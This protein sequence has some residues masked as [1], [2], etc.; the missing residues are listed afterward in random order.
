MTAPAAPNDA[1]APAVS[2]LELF[3]HAQPLD[4][5][6]MLVGSLAALGLGA[7]QPIQ[8]IF[9]ADV[10]DAVGSAGLTG[11]TS[12]VSSD[13]ESAIFAFL[14]IAV[15]AF[16]CGFIGTFAWKWTGERQAAR[17]RM[18]YLRAIMRQD[19]AWHDAR[20]TAGL[21]S[22]FAETAQLVELGIGTKLSEGLRFLGQALGGVATGFYFEWDIALVLLA[23]APFSIGSAAGLNTVTRRTSQRMAEA[24]G[25]AGAVCAEVLG[26]V[27]T[28]ASFS[29]EPRE[30][31]R[32]EALLAPAEAVGIRSG[33]QRGLA[34]GAMMG[35]ENVLMAVGLVYGA[36]K[37]ASERARGE[38]NCAYTNSCKVSGGEVLLT[39]FAI[40]MGAQAFGFLGQA[41][42]ALSKA[43]TAAGRMKLTIERTPSIDAMSDEGLTPDATSVR[44]R[45][46]FAHCAFRYPARPDVP[47]YSDFSLV[48]E[49]GTTVALV[50]GSGSG[51]ST[52]VALVERFYDPDAGAVLLDG[53]DVRRLQLRWLRQR[54]GLVGQ[55]PTLFDG[56]IAQNIA[57]GKPDATPE[58]IEEAARSSNA[59]GFI[60]AFP[61]GYGTRVGQGGGQLSGGQKQR[62]AIARAILKNPPV[63]LLDEATSAL[64]NESE[65]VVQAAL[66]ALLA[67]QKRTTIVIAHRLSTIRTADKIAVVGQGRVLEE[68]SHNQ[69]MRKGEQGHYYRLAHLADPGGGTG[70]GA[71]AASAVKSL[72]GA[73]TPSA[74]ADVAVAAPAAAPPSPAAAQSGSSAVRAVPASRSPR[75]LEAGGAPHAADDARAEKAAVAE[76]KKARAAAHKAQRARVWAMQRPERPYLALAMTGAVGLGATTPL[77]GVFFAYLLRLFFYP[78]PERIMREAWTWGGIFL[79]LAA[80]QFCLELARTWGL[81]VV[82]ERLTRRLRADAFEAMLRQDM[83]W[84]DEPSNSAANLSANLS[85]DITLVSAVTGES[86]GN[87][88]ANLS[89]IAVGLVLMFALGV[90]QLALIAIC[91]VPVIGAAIAIEF[92]TMVGDGDANASAGKEDGDDDVAGV[93]EDAI[94]IAARRKR[95]ADAAKRTAAD[96]GREAR[97]RAARIVGQ[98]A[99]SVRTVASFGLESALF[100]DYAAATLVAQRERSRKATVPAFT[101]GFS[102]FMM[103]ASILVVYWYGGILVAQGDADFASMFTVILVMFYMAFGLGQISQGA[104]DQE[105]AARA[106]GR[107]MTIMDRRPPK[108]KASTFVSRDAMS[109]EGL[110]PDAAS[111]RGR[112]EFAH[113]AFRYPARPDVPIYSD[114]SLVI[115]A[116]TTV[117]LV[118]GSGSGKS[119]AVALVE[120]FYDPDAGAVLLDGV[121]VRRLQLR[122]LRQRVGLVGQEPTLFDGTIAQNIAYGKPDATPEQI[123]EAARSS[124]AH[125]FISAFPDGYGTRVGQG[126][127]QL[128]GGQKQ[129]VAIAR[130]ILKNPPVLLL[131]EATSAL[132]N[133]S[134]RV[135][136]AAL[137]ALLAT[138]KRTTIVIAH[139]LST[140]RTADKIAVVGQGRVLEEGS[141]N[142]LM[143]KGGHYHA[144][145]T[146]KGNA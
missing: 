52:A 10:I 62:V 94:D 139:R 41:I 26:A 135:V 88:I 125:G 28:V 9:V 112:I 50:G 29:A 141:H 12:N 48:I 31:A 74:A 11:D 53:V 36:F 17:Y 73:P 39:I 132:D 83:P 22:T 117:A 72:F 6:V 108:S 27:R 113:C 120:R 66:D 95:E 106:V 81:A 100:A 105:K 23:I 137:D 85:R 110:T 89:T 70:T 7:I 32:F 56:T 25:S 65:R 107:I 98:L 37:I 129:R 8:F 136:Q 1:S 4:M 82:R 97:E 103:I 91:I 124:N 87:L 69:L 24:F 51:K 35:T 77:M 104:T 43:R 84:F 30:R 86:T 67:T 101:T 71:F 47:I 14:Y 46:E 145:V 102:Q 19:I 109:D 5:L 116:G 13:V 142:Q 38:S 42:T 78:E 18:A 119:T 115:E 96:K 21:A 121:D 92:M 111:V 44:G 126:G 59:H 2:L 146:A 64:D 131:D 63:L 143:R 15:A 16:A 99:A 118:G 93:Q 57:Y 140:I 90:W 76:A 49:A 60:S 68:G 58:Q 134:E 54:V 75:E 128:S 122:W 40:D 33:W 114:F 127:G 34:M 55:E 144:L 3:Q 80:A 79:A 61:D 133:E 130:A 45:I 138:Q 123:E 20:S